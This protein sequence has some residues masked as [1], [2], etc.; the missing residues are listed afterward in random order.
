MLFQALRRHPCLK[1]DLSRLARGLTARLSARS[2]GHRADPACHDYDRGRNP[3]KRR[4]ASNAAE[5][6]P[7]VRVVHD[8]I[9]MRASGKWQQHNRRGDIAE[10][11]MIET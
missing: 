7:L 10:G 8:V 11:A 1:S 9:L 5:L 3:K 6:A 2:A 4:R